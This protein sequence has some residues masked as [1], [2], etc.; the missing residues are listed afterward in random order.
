MVV[1]DK[2]TKETDF[3]P[4]KTTHMT[5]NIGEIYMKKVSRIHGVSKT[6]V[7]DIYPKFTSNF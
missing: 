1:V 4:V 3:I 2:L 6:I 7:L 5:T